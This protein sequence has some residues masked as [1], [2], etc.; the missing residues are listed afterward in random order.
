MLYLA[1]LQAVDNTEQLTCQMSKLLTSGYDIALLFPRTIAVLRGKSSAV[2]FGSRP[3]EYD[4][5]CN[6]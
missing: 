3:T 4:K 5:Y 2:S 6:E 1:A